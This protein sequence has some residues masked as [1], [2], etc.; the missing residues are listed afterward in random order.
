MEE[1]VRNSI[2]GSSSEENKKMSGTGVKLLVQSHPL[3]N[4]HERQEDILLHSYSTAC[5][6]MRGM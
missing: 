3:Q 1:K 6:H 2:Q 4:G 5:N